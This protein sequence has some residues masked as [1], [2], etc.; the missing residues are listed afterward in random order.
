MLREWRGKND[1]RPDLGW[2]HELGVLILFLA[3]AWCIW[4]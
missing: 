4:Q 2:E 1:R 3:V